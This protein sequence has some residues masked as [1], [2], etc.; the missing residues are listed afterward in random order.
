MATHP[1]LIRFAK[2][3]GALSLIGLAPL[4]SQAGNPWASEPTEIPEE[5]YES[6]DLTRQTRNAPH[7]IGVQGSV[8]F[9]VKAKFIPDIA[10]HVP[11]T[12]Q[13]VLDFTIAGYSRGLF[14]GGNVLA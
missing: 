10:R 8:M 1:S 7:R 14:L 2:F 11:H 6:V 9:G 3:A 4:A 5:A 12:S 13:D